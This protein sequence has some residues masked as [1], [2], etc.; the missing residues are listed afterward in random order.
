M[1]RIT[2]RG[3]FLRADEVAE[4]FKISRAAAYVAARRWL[5]TGGRE[6]I[7]CV[8]VGRS[9]RFLASAIDEMATSRPPQP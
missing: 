4:V 6:G 3:P 5:D 2:D 1:A 7:P 8:R 9:V